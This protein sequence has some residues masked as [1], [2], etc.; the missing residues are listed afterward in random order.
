MHRRCRCLNLLLE[1][2]H[3]VLP[4]GL[5]RGVRSAGEQ[6]HPVLSSS[7][8]TVM[9]GQGA[10][11]ECVCAGQRGCKGRFERA[12][13]QRAPRFVFQSGW[14][15][16]LLFASFIS[17]LSDPKKQLR[18]QKTVSL[19]GKKTKQNNAKTKKIKGA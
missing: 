18:T 11:G 12:G 15:F 5:V 9:P 2:S 7:W 16:R 19:E 13:S 10:A 17:L 3:Q 4:G 8:V 14:K 1:T 6:L